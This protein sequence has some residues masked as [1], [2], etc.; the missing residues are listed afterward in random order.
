MTPQAVLSSPRA[1]CEGRVLPG[2]P[3][4]C[5]F[6]PQWLQ[7]MLGQVLDAVDYLHH[8]DVIHR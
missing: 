4:R 2:R 1:A 7:N 6:L 3:S 5:L 8:L